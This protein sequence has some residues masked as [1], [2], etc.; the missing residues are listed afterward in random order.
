MNKK[1]IP[2]VSAALLLAVGAYSLSDTTPET[3]PIDIEASTQNGKNILELTALQD[4]LQINDIIVN[5]GNCKVQLSYSQ[6]DLI[7]NKPRPR[8]PITL[9]YGQSTQAWTY[10][11]GCNLRE[12]TVQT[13]QDDWT[14]TW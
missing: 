8:F 14:W 4:N 2:I 3:S 11:K 10:T 6:L 9:K 7:Q 1:I 12:A 13:N 5:R